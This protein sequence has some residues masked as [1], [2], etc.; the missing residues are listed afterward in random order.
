[1][2]LQDVILW[3]VVLLTII[4]VL[5]YVFGNSP[6]FEQAILVL[7]LGLSITAVVKLR[8]LEARFNFLARDFREHTKKR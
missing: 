2:K 1:M 7:L 8:V 6:T 5:W 4:V 3:L